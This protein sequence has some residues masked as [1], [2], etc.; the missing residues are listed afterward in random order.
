MT[1]KEVRVFSWPNLDYL[2]E[3]KV[4]IVTIEITYSV[5]I[6][7]IETSITILGTDDCSLKDRRMPYLDVTPCQAMM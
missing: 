3:N 2:Q 4:D 5:K 1:E 6:M 7:Q